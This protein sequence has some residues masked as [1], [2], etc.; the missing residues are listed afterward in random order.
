M[1]IRTEILTI[2]PE[3][4]E[5]YRPQVTLEPVVQTQETRDRWLTWLNDPEISQWMYSNNP[6]TPGEIH[7]WI[8][9]VISDA[10]RHYFTINADGKPVGFVS[11]RQD[12]HPQNTAEIGI[13]I[14]EK[15]H[16]D[17]G[18]GAQT[19]EQVLAY[20]KDEL[21]LE[22]VRAMIKTANVRSI[23]LFTHAGF[24]ETKRETINNAPMI[25]FEK[26]LT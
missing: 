9:R 13:V 4:W 21:H 11:L 1:A 5:V 22:S 17:R 19:V 25:R 12:Q 7:R 6:Y 18:V 14:G 23:R 2:N 3:Q 26:K 10:K 16:W 24:V 8:D 15:D 20:A